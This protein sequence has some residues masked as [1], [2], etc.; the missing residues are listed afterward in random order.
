M[1]L[2]KFLSLSGITSR[3]KAVDEIKSGYVTVNDQIVKDPVYTVKKGDIVKYKD[4]KIGPEKHLYIILNKP[5]GYLTTLSDIN[6]RQNVM[7]LIKLKNKTR[8][9]PVGRL[10]KDTTGLLFITNDGDLAQHLSHPK[11]E[12]SKLY[13]VV[14]DQEFDSSNFAKLLK[15]IHLKD[16][17]TKA[18][19]VFYTKKPNRKKVSIELHSGKNRIVRRLFKALGY[20]VI[21]LDRTR[22]AGLVKRGLP[23]GKW[24]FL[25]EEE[26]V[27]LK[28]I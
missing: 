9:Y 6:G 11:Y 8:V 2:N 14:L 23:K 4:K 27:N 26:I 17:I 28:L 10:D 7:E 12:V 5:T 25:T 20:N 21:K 15:G 22:Y 13:E 19:K 16:G 24:R 18:D 3:R 1:F